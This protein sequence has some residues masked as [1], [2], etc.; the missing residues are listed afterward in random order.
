MIN[1]NH[2]GEAVG[3]ILFIPLVFVFQ[4]SVKQ[5]LEGDWDKAEPRGRSFPSQQLQRC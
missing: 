2:E 3:V 1:R 4:T 5:N